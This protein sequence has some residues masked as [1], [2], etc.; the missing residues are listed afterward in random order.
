M[1]R[2]GPLHGKASLFNLPVKKAAAAAMVKRGGCDIAREARTAAPGR[3]TGV[4]RRCGKILPFNRTV[5]YN[6]KSA[7]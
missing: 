1:R 4:R 3:K 2:H 6:H 7:H 5:Q